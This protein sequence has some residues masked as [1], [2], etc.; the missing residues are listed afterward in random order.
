LG[1]DVQEFGTNTFVIHGKPAHIDPNA[2]DEQLIKQMLEQY[3]MNLD[4]KLEATENIAQS[5]AVSAS[6]K[7]GKN[8]TK[9]EMLDLINELFACEVPYQSPT[10]RKCFISI[11]LDELMKRFSI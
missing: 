7:R 10:G 5:F 4:L 11:G 1:F 3:K 6:V 8:L 2:N 9:E